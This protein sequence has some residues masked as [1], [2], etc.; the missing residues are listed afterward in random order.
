MPQT[1]MNPSPESA[2]SRYG[3]DRNLSR[4]H[5]ILHAIHR[6]QIKTWG[7]A[8]HTPRAHATDCLNF[9]KNIR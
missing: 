3:S 1:I 4:F 6:D 5:Q 2:I 8:Q 9:T 7:V